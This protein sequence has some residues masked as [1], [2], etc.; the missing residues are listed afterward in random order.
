MMP[1]PLQHDGSLMNKVQTNMGTNEPGTAQ[2]LQ[3]VGMPG[4]IVQLPDFQVPMLQGGLTTFD[5]SSYP[6]LDAGIDSGIFSTQPLQYPFEPMTSLD[7]IVDFGAF[8]GTGGSS[9]YSPQSSDSMDVFDFFSAGD[10]S[11][12]A[13]FS[14]QPQDSDMELGLDDTG[15]TTQWAL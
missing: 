13:L 7:T 3:Q 5:I 11:A 4:S 10:P 12:D 8:G 15:N 2:I 6:P 1:I 14:L 9:G